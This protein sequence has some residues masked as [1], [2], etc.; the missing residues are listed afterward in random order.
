MHTILI[1]L[2]ELR[3]FVACCR[4]R[5]IVCFNLMMPISKFRLKGRV[6]YRGGNP[7][8][9][10]NFPPLQK[11]IF[12]KLASLQFNSSVFQLKNI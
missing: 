2:S 1:S 10:G 12:L 8:P 9:S 5:F 6:S 3:I 7:T 4:I 11:A